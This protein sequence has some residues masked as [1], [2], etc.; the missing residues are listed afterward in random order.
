MSVDTIALINDSTNLLVALILLLGMY[1]GVAMRR[2][3][4]NPTYRARAT[5]SVF[6]MLV[7]LISFVVGFAPIPSTGPLSSLG[8]LPFL[9]IVVTAFAYAD[10]SVVVATETDFF[11]RNTLGWLRGRRPAGVIMVA[12]VVILVVLGLIL[13]AQPPLWASIVADSLFLLI[14]ADLGYATAALIV[15]ARRSSDRALRRSIL[16]L[17]LALFTLVLDLAL[18]TP[19]NEGTLPFVIVSQGTAVVGIYLIYRSVMSLSPLG[20]LEKATGGT[21]GPV[22]HDNA[23]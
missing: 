7:I 4:V 11:H 2:A 16:F 23:S 21:T 15:G 14:A 13:P 6:F 9:A 17:G 20:R 18:T 1:R 8:F 10:R 5:W 22:S 12:C 19:L 3:F